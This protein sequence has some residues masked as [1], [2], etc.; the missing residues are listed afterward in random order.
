MVR[1]KAAKITDNDLAGPGFNSIVVRLKGNTDYPPI[2]PVLSFNSIVV[3]L[4]VQRA[5]LNNQVIAV[6]IP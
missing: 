5:G 2:D 4:K 3:R 6:S 1:L